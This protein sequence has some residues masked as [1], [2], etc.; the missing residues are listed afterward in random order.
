[1]KAVRRGKVIALSASKKKLDDAYSSNL[2]AHLKVLEQ[3]EANLPKRSRQ[4]EIIKLR[5]KINQ[6]QI[7]RTI[8]KIN[9]TK[10]WFFEKINKIV[11]PLTRLTRGHRDS[12]LI[13]KIRNE[14][15]DITTESEE[16]KKKIIISYST[17]LENM[18]EMDNFPDRFKLQKLNQDQIDDKKQSHIT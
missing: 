3:K 17:K 7:K 12:I 13:N 16:I 11:K 1:M 15:G 14:R 2:T 10:S 8:Q 5:A 18:V 4:Q 6:V 9:Q